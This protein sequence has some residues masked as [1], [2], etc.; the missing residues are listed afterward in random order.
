MPTRTD[1]FTQL[2][3]IHTS[4]NSIICPKCQSIKSIKTGKENGIQKFRCKTCGCNYRETNH[5]P[6]YRL[7]KKKQISIYMRCM[8][9]GYS[10][11]KSAKISDISLATAF[12][13]R[14]RFLE[15]VK[16]TT[17]QTS[18]KATMSVINLP[19]SNK[20]SRENAAKRPVQ[21]SAIIRIGN[22]SMQIIKLK[23]QNKTFHIQQLTAQLLSKSQEIQICAGPLLSKAFR[24][25]HKATKHNTCLETPALLSWLETFR[26]VASKYL[27]NYWSWYRLLDE[28]KKKTSFPEGL[29]FQ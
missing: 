19:F 18:S 12:A 3:K 25:H 5:S 16:P 13:W 27:Q 7:K 4:F 6:L 26:G 1:S 28:Q 21:S 29:L 10:L 23:N 22:R 15:K 8:E 17:E 2:I 9:Q 20:G 24:F 11:R 14:H